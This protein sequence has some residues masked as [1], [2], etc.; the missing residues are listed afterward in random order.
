MSKN[1]KLTKKEFENLI[2]NVATSA[3]TA[4]IKELGLDKVDRKFGMYPGDVTG[5]TEADLKAM[6][7]SQRVAEFIKAVF[8]KD[9]ALIK[10][11]NEGTGSAGGFSVPEE[12]AAEINRIAEDFGLVRKF[13]RRITMTS[14]TLNL[15]RLGSSVQVTF[16]GEGVAGTAS[17]FVQQ[18]V[19][20]LAKTAVGLTVASNELLE[21]ANVD[22][23]QF[24]LELFAEELAGTEDEQGLVGTGSPFTGIL[25]DAGVNVVDMASGN[26]NFSDVTLDDLRDMVSELKPL[27][28]NGA[29]Y[30][31]HR[32]VWGIVQKLKDA[33]SAYHIS[34]ANPVLLP[35]DTGAA[36]GGVV[37]GAVWG[38]P[39]WLSEKM[40]SV[41]G[42]STKFIS[43]GNY[44]K[45]WFG[46]RKQMTMKISEDATV[47][48]DNVFEQ[49]QSAVRVTERFAIAIGLPDGFV[50]VKTA[51]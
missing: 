18:N 8:V 46:D 50:V 36:I 14:D 49:N 42:V 30:T 29:A 10:A 22:I 45:L 12:F 4:K 24:L 38:Y 40:P 39:V 26:T 1:L 47:G 37:V 44:N 43:F 23:A 21:D 25:G 16:P 48:S 11:L 15:P 35:G 32:S 33:D 2:T 31:M 41:T 28:L 3:L 7:K 9:R 19:Q 51:A 6:D 27:A 34:A 20:L 5:K 17:Q 13:A